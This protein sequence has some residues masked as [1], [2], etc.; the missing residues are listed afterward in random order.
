LALDLIGEMEFGTRRTYLDTEHTLTHFRQI[1]WQT[2]LLDRTYCDHTAPVMLGDEK[3]LQAADQRW[4]DLV[5]AQPSPD[6]DSKFVGE[7]NR[8]V[9]AARRELLT[10]ES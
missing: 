3:L 10:E 2:Q 8:I 1:G 6:P 5:A 9:A 4:R 7:L